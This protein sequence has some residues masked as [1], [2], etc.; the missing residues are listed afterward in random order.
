MTGADPG[1]FDN[2]YGL[3]GEIGHGGMAV[4]Y[5]AQDERLN[6]TVAIKM[7]RPQF[8]SDPNFL[9]RFRREAQAVASLSHPNLA[10]VWDSGEVNGVPYIVMEFVDGDNLKTRIAAQA[11]FTAERAVALMIQ[12]CDGV[13]AA[14]R[15]GIVHRDLKP[16]NILL[17]RTGQIKVTDF[18]IA[19]S[20]AAT[21]VSS[22]Q[23][24]QVWG[25]AQY[26]AP[27]QASGQPVSPATD[28]YSLGIILFEM[29]TGR[30]PFEADTPL[31]LAM[32]HL[33]TEPPSIRTFNPAIPVGLEGIV[34][35]AMA[36][37]P[38]ARYPDADA[39][40]SALKAYQRLGEQATGPMPTAS[41]PQATPAAPRP[42]VPAPGGR[43][44][45][46]VPSYTPPPA[47]T[48]P[49]ADWST[50]GLGVLAAIAV[51]GLI[52]LYWSI[53]QRFSGG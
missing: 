28:V 10:A 33:Q 43:P 19:R 44:V 35:K 17:A 15:A 8:A 39:L 31:A 21:A 40:G 26:I 1:L 14:H 24:G 46:T 18:G 36:K 48:A 42:A 30:L 12:I 47:S 45:S 27:E 25:T 32:Q 29:L 2:R 23:T 13:G 34:T 51:L 49:E 52:P 6:R 50:I 22:T 11:P 7:M 4:V 53:I 9:L 5:R 20:L 37:R 38:Q 16:Q 3:Q 41:R